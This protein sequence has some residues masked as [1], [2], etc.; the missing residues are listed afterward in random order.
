MAVMCIE[1]EEHYSDN[2]LD[3]FVCNV[4]NLVGLK[5]DN[6]NNISRVNDL[7]PLFLECMKSLI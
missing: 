1:H 5:M 6:N 4:S 3:D 2:Y 7:M